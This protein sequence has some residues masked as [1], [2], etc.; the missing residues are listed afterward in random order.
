VSVDFPWTDGQV[1]A[2]QAMGF[3]MESTHIFKKRL[4]QERW[5]WL[6]AVAQQSGP[7]KWHALLGNQFKYNQITK[8]VPVFDDILTAA[9]F[10]ETLGDQLQ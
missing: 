8:T 9:V 2:V 6:I 7:P 5:L 10:C 4:A 1:L 3:K